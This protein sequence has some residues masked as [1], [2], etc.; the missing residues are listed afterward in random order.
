LIPLFGQNP[1]VVGFR[2]DPLAFICS[3]S[4]G[5]GLQGLSS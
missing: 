1:E 4:Q 3:E 2:Q 5:W